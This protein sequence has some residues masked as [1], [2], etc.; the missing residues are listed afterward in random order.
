MKTLL[1]IAL[2][3]CALVNVGRAGEIP[4]EE[5]KNH[6]GETTTVKGVVEQVTKGPKSV[7]LN[8]G[9]HYPDQ[10]FT[11]V[12]FNLPFSALSS[13]EGKTVSVTGAISSNNGKPGMTVN[14]LTQIVK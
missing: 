6:I 2:S 14:N 13:F 7:F 10:T 5:A 9:G 8:F 3:L 12:S 11:V 4:V 1:A